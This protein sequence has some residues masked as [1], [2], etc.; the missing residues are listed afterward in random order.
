MTKAVLI[1]AELIEADN[2]F[3]SLN[4]NVALLNIHHPS[5]ATILT[6]TY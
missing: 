6:N 5:K 3:N 1:E 4:Q 2:T